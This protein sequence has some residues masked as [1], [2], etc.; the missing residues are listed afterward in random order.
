M[1]FSS[2]R[3]QDL[4]S[5]SPSPAPS[6]SDFALR[7]RLQQQCE[8]VYQLSPSAKETVNAAITASIPSPA[9][10]NVP[11]QE[12]EAF[13]FRLF[14]KPVLKP[15]ASDQAPNKPSRVFIRS[16]SPVAGEPGFVQPRRSDN[17]YFA[18]APTSEERACFETASISADAIIA[19]QARRWV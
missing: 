3:R 11:A 16:L 5:T 4:Y 14:S 10:G 1:L 19:E 18:S 2:I 8:A 7:A 9:V 15:N 17:Y 6:T 13:E 12:E